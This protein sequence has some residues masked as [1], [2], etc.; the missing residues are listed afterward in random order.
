M[1][2]VMQI[3]CNHIPG[4]SLVVLVVKNPPANAVPQETRVWSLG[5]KDPPAIEN[6]NLLQNSCLENPRDSGA[7][8]HFFISRDKAGN[9]FN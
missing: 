6:G 3:A 7:W 4:G 2:G 1:T 5:R 9:G 8:L